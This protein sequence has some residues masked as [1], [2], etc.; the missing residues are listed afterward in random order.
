MRNNILLLLSII[1][2]T[3]CD[4]AADAPAPSAPYERWK[5]Q[6]LH[7]Y[8]MEQV[9]ACFC[10]DGGTRMKVIVKQDTVFSVMRLS[11]ST[12]LS[13]PQTRTYLP[14]DSLFSIIRNPG[15]DS[16]VVEY[17]PDLGYP[18]KLDINPQ[19]HPVDGG[20]LYETSAL[21]PLQ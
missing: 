12:M 7:S 1:L 13:Y 19:Q 4:D 17:H 14:I 18:I 21:Q 16:L 5:S 9:R 6:N 2:L 11:D 15:S 3:G 20:V 8:S 10:I